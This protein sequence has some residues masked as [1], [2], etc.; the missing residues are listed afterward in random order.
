MNIRIAAF[1]SCL[2]ALA[3]APALALAAN[4]VKIGDV[5][6][7]VSVYVDKESIRRSGTQVRA[8]LEWRWTTPTELPDNP[9]RSYVMERQVQVSNCDNKSFAIAEGTRYADERGIDAVASYKNDESTL[10][11]TV[12]P[13]RTIRDVVVAYVC[14]AAPPVKKP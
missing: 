1:S 2:V 13:P 5:P 10:P 3:A 7:K 8:A 4:L 11:Y 12:A 14:A 9:G 6:G